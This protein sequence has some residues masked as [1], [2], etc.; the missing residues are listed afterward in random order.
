MLDEICPNCGGDPGPM[1]TGTGMNTC[2]LCGHTFYMKSPAVPG[3]E[4][5]RPDLAPRAGLDDDPAPTDAASVDAGSDVEAT[6]STL[7]NEGS[8]A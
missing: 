5:S 1:T 4:V 6:S 8:P 3:S 7:E 2:D